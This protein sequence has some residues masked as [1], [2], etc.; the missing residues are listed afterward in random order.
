[1]SAERGFSLIELMVSMAAFLVVFSAILMM[2]QVATHNQADVASKV[3]T[4]Q[5]ARP[6]MTNLI[7]RLH[8]SCVAPGVAPI[9]AGSSGTSMVFIS[10]S[11]ADV[12]PTPDRY[13][14]SLS[15]DTLSESRY[16]ATG[17][18]PPSWTF[19][20][21]PTSTRE[22]I[23]GVGQGS[24]GDPPVTVPLFRY[25]AYVGGQLSPTPLPTPLSTADAAST[26]HV[27]VAFAASPSEG[28]VP[29]PNAP[30]TLADSTTLRLEPASEDSAE[31][32]LPCA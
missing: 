1:M 10:R 21:T 5:R 19:S 17:G 25:F 22:L 9:Q 13:V 7:D 2:V 24:I 15:G 32:N 12:N 8:S 26:V 27:T 14:I 20:P 23:S 3:A 30:I 29:N 31:V 18:A 6:V 28:S 16:A 4:N 11:G